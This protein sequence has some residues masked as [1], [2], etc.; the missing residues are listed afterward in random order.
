MPVFLLHGQD[1]QIAEPEFSGIV[2]L[3]RDQQTGEPLEKQKASSGS[4][5]SVGAALFGVARAKG[6]NFVN[7][8]RST[9]RIGQGSEIR[10]IVRAGNND[11]DPM[12][13]INIFALESEPDKDRRQIVTG[14]VNFNKSTAAAIDFLPFQASRYKDSSYLLEV[15]PLPPG[16]YALT[17]DGSRDVFNM[18]G[19]DSE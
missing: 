9:V 3:V 5:A 10:L 12:E 7:A 2:L 13:L 18:F 16:E 14:T 1:L 17:L 11:R 15:S 19:V 8:A 6:M 4:K